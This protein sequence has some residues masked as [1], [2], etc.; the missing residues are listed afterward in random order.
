MKN[1]CTGIGSL[2]D[3]ARHLRLRDSISLN[4]FLPERFKYDKKMRVRTLLAV[5]LIMVLSIGP[6]LAANCSAICFSLEQNI[7]SAMEE[8]AGAMTNCEHCPKP[9][10]V[11]ESSYS[12]DECNMAGC[13]VTAAA[14]FHS[15]TSSN[16]QPGENAPPQFVFNTVSADLPPPIKPPA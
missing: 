15:E 2:D 13:H 7:T 3:L 8:G 14:Y 5:V 10:P 12:S 11:N 16:A 6:A 1:G 4:L 9:E